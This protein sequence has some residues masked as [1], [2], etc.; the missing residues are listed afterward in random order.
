MISTQAAAY[1]QLSPCTVDRAL[2]LH[3]SQFNN[4]VI[5]VFP[6]N[7]MYSHSR[8]VT[9]LEVHLCSPSSSQHPV[10]PCG[11]HFCSM[12]RH[13][14]CHHGVGTPGG[15]GCSPQPGVGSCYRSH[16][17]ASAAVCLFVRDVT[18][19]ELGSTWVDLH[20]LPDIASEKKNQT[21]TANPLGF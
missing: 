19:R 6:L 3:C 11:I 7:I 13:Q 8:A 10:F 9:V 20:L 17:R 21:N 15:G 14:S 1:L 12:K 16:W 18:Q 4:S 5:A 2:P